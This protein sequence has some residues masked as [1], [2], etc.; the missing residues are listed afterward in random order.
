MTKG[1]LRHRN[2]PPR[3]NASAANSN[4]WQTRKGELMRQRIVDA[5]INCI[6]QHGYHSTTMARVAESAGVSQ[7]AMQYHFA[8]KLDLIEAAIH[9]LEQRRLRDRDRDLAERPQ[10]VDPLAHGIEVYWQHVS[11]PEFVAYQELLLAARTNPELAAVLKPAYRRFIRQYRN[12]SAK[13]VSEWQRSRPEF[14][15]AADLIQHLLEGL[16][17]GRM[18]DQLSN[19]QTRRVIELARGLMVTWFQQHTDDQRSSEPSR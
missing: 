17:Y 16:A 1:N 11:H 18:N 19:A 6:V 15:L 10:G 14:E 2:T 7:G 3:A 12:A 9:C 13:Q 8:S 5:T 4:T